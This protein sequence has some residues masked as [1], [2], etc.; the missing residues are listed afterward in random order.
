[1]Q[2]VHVVYLDTDIHV[3]LVRV[4]LNQRRQSG[5]KSGDRGSGFKIWGLCSG[6]S[7]IFCLGGLMGIK[8]RRRETAIAEGKKFLTTRGSSGSRT[9]QTGGQILAG[10]FERPFFTRLP[11]KF[12][13]FPKNISSISQKFLMTFFFIFLVIDLFYV[14]ICFLQLEQNFR[15]AKSFL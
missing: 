14:L 6:G 9:S 4:R 3:G 12:L 2:R 5:L 8:R 13:H 1:M 15:G 11:T 7:R 10:I